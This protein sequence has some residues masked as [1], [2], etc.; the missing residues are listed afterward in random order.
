MALWS[1]QSLRLDLDDTAKLILAGLLE[2]ANKDG[3]CWPS[4]EVIHQFTSASPATVTRKLRLLECQ[5][6]IQRQK[7]CSQSS[8]FRVNISRLEQ[9]EAKRLAERKRR[10]PRGFEPFEDETPQHIENVSNAHSEHSSD[11]SEHSSDHSDQHNPFKNPLM[12]IRDLKIEN[13]TNFERSQICKGE[14][15]LVKATGNAPLNRSHPVYQ[16]LARQMRA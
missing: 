6:W 4:R 15:V 2:H 14:R 8:L 12:K 13:L 3:V 1:L 11:H 10:L 9:L 7:R 16:R 5:G